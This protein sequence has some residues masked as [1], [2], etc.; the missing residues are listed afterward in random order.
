MV[1]ILIKG[2]IWRHTHMQGEHHT[3]KEMKAEI[4]GMLPQAKEIQRLPGA[5]QKLEE[6]Q[7]TDCPSPP[8][9]GTNPT[10]TLIQDC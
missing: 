10:N 1:G 2:E 9:K 6:R 8:A 3:Q 5:H 7:G 4:G